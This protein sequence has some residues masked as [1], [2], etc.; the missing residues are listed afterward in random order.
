MCN[1]T[2]YSFDVESGNVRVG[3]IVYDASGVYSTMHLGSYSDKDDLFRQID[4]TRYL[5]RTETPDNAIGKY[6]KC[7]NISNTK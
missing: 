4:A 3:L 6:G 7:S 5:H 2:A 1:L